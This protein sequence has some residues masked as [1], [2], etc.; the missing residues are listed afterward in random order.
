MDK[1]GNNHGNPNGETSS[2]SHTLATT[3]PRSGGSNT[4][5]DYSSDGPP[6]YQHHTNSLDKRNYISSYVG[7][8]INSYISGPIIEL[9]FL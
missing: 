4:H 6:K 9:V 2:S 7:E 3:L 1:C 5:Q 8:Y